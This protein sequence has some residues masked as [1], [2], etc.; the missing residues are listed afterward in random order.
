MAARPGGLHKRSSG[1]PTPPTRPVS[2]HQSRGIRRETAKPP[3]VLPALASRHTICQPA[4]NLFVATH[5][6]Q[7]T[8]P[9]GGSMESQSAYTG[10][11]SIIDRMKGAAMLDV[12]TYEEVE[13][14]TTATNQ[15]AGVGATLA[16]P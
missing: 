15:A 14:D 5:E 2:S 10:R 3:S 12:A 13:A 8:P 11:R 16:P 9:P 6:A 7:H 1:I 4:V